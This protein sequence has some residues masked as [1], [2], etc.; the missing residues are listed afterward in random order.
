[1]KI[2]ILTYGRIANF[3]ANLQCT[4]TYMY[5]LSHG[6]NP[7]YIYYLPKDLYN[8]IE[9]NR[10][11]NPQ[12]QAHYDYFDSIVKNSTN[13]CHTPEDINKAI[14]D[15]SIEAVI[16]GADAV[17]QHHPLLSR[18]RF[19][20]GARFVYLDD[21]TKDRLFPNLFWGYGVDDRVKIAMMS[22]SCQN[23]E[24]SLF[25]PSVKRKMRNALK[26]FGYISVR[27]LWTQKMIMHIDKTRNVP[28]TPDPVFAF[29]YNMS[30][31]IPTKDAIS[32]KFDLP[33][34]YVVLSF[35][36]QSLSIQCLESIKDLF[37]RK[38]IECVVLPMPIQGVNFKHGFDK[39]VKAPLSPLDW[40]AIIKYSVGYIG[41]N[42]HPIVTCLHNGV[43]CFSIDNW[44]RRG[45]FNQIKN[46]GSSKTADIMRIF[47]VVEYRKSILQ[48]P[49]KV[50]ALEIYNAII[51]FPVD[52]IKTK[53][54]DY[55]QRYENLMDS[56][57]NYFTA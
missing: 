31:L 28:I 4:S 1:M 45:V 22:V 36:A 18:I 23:S 50:D 54:N 7:I 51:N 12:I 21:I 9:R 15:N 55:Y 46:D 25:L 6:H 57:L 49:C 44:G 5:L 35:F 13:L 33:E 39:V 42:M 34:K 27:D 38:K 47:D 10:E 43:P 56:I 40:Y 48:R 11:I 26:R 29:N 3:G 37:K 52:K 17:L 16:I 32:E 30:S 8:S 2:G 24:Y 14:K 19:R 41:E 53:S 20:K